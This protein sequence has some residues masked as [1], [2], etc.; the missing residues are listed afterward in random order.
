[1]GRPRKPVRSRK[2]RR[3]STCDECGL[4]ILVGDRIVSVGQG[5]WVHIRHLL[6]AAAR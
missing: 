5:P 6:A 4:V 3:Q 1:V 2:A